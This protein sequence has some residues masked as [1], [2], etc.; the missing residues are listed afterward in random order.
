MARLEEMPP[1]KIVVCPKCM[2]KEEKKYKC[3]LCNTPGLVN[4]TTALDYCEEWEK[5]N[6]KRIEDG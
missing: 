3:D 6:T 4:V 1:N 2:G 5:R